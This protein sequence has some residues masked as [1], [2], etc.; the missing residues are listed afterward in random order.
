MRPLASPWRRALVP[1]LAGLVLLGLVPL[2]YGLR[3]D[4]GAVGAALLWGGSVLQVAVGLWL[5]SRALAE[6]IPG[7]LSGPG[8]LARD[9][10]LGLLAMVA[11]T[12]LTFAASPTHV[13]GSGARYFE[14]CLTR[15]TLLGLGPLVVSVALLARGLLMRPAIT[16]ALA[17][18]GAGLFADSSW[19]L[20]CEVSDPAHVLTAHLGAVAVVTL[21][22]T[23]AG[24]L[25]GRGQ[26]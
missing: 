22:G 20:Y 17:G 3:F 8:A 11:L 19:R 4:R 2:I 7:R 10:G 26:S 21:A 16:G 9:L 12:L 18:L 6:T 23:A 15:S 1:G 14:V 24:L 13:P 5:V 25:A